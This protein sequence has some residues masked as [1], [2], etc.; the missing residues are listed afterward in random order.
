M[1]PAACTR[2]EF[3]DRR[4]FGFVRWELKGAQDSMVRLS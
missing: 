1:S 2:A 4:L 3:G